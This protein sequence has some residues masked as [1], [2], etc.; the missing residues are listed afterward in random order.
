MPHQPAGRD[1]LLHEVTGI[2]KDPPV[3]HVTDCDGTAWDLLRGWLE[4][5]A[6]RVSGVR[7]RRG[8]EVTAVHSSH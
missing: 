7:A 5:H 6:V 2:G 1:S 3:L 8:T 4:E